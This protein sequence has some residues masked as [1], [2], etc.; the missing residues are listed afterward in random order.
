MAKKTLS[1]QQNQMMTDEISTSGPLNGQF[2][3]TDEALT[4]YEP[5]ASRGFNQL[6][7]VQRQGRWFLLK[8]LKPEFQQQPVYLELL[9]KEYALMVQL[10]HPNIVKAYAK[11]VNDKLGPCI[12]MEYID[13]VKLDEF[14]AGKPPRQARRKVVDQLVDA[15][16]YLHSK[17]I[18]H[19]DL[20]PSNILV[21]RNGNNV[22]IIDFGLSD[23]DDYAVLKQSAGTLSYMAPEQMEQSQK[24]DCRAD[25]YSLGLLLRLIFPHRYRFIEAKCMRKNPERRYADM[26][27][28]R[29]ALERHDR[30]ARTLP[31]LV[32]L[33]L[34]LLYGFLLSNRIAQQQ[35]TSDNLTIESSSPFLNNQYFK[36]YVDNVVI[37]Q[38]NTMIHPILIEAE[39]GNE[40]KEVLV[41]RLSH[42]S[43]DIKAL[44]HEKG[45]LYPEN[46]Q[47]SL[48][49]ITQTRKRQKEF[50]RIVLD[51]IN[52]HC[53]SYKED[54]QK[55]QISQTEY[56]SLEWLIS[57]RII[58]MPIDDITPTE[59]TG[60]I[61]VLEKGYYGGMELGLCWD[62][63]HNPTIKGRHSSCDPVSGRVV[64][65][66]LIPNTT[67]F[68]RA[69]VTNTAGT[70]Y[71]NEMTFT[72]LPSDSIIPLP[73]GA[74]PGLFSVS[75]GRQVH[76]SKG[77]LQ[78]QASTGTWRFAE[79]QYDFVGKDNEKISESF[80]GW[81]DLFGWATSGYDHG[82]VNWQP[83]SSNLVAKSDPLHYAYGDVSYNLDDLTGQA[84]WG[85]N[86]IS[87]G[88]NKENIG[89]HTPSRDDWM[90]LLFVR[91]TASGARFAKAVVG[92][93][94]GL[95]L[96]P[97]NW[98]VATY[99]LN[100]VNNAEL[101]YNTNI[102]SLSDWQQ[103][104]EPLGAVFLPEAGVRT[105]DGVFS[106][107]GY[108][109]TSNH[110][111]EKVYQMSFGYG[112]TGIYL[113]GH[114]GDG[115]SVR[116]VRE[117]E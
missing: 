66:R 105:I 68:A 45:C 84:D 35:I 24:L 107:A 7:K 32:V 83:W 77:N 88:G 76:F 23:A 94:N 113:A 27:A 56:D 81:I 47:E 63:L 36:D 5:L 8:G 102:I 50:E 2:L 51:Q 52:A 41:E 4:S 21:T 92:G 10:D 96:L 104:L 12:V 25:I 38:V 31:L 40:Y 9:K 46:S 108:Y 18:Q 72:T 115:Q 53:R 29:K 57:P 79:H 78:Y 11:E 110:T 30:R 39:Q 58:T 43:A 114:R 61:D 103:V 95:V 16:S 37:W 86:A 75:E 13:G 42:I 49:L 28:V 109:Q 19:R 48:E 112:C 111:I 54:F 17:Q 1:S 14:L 55:H 100:S 65:S 59:A 62:M 34:A 44:L 26:E 85:Y 116:L 87:N 6:V 99:Q 15:L 89:W 82:A 3:S 91:N 101:G 71:G 97:D 106:D 93:T 70:F 80:A 117:V 22:K 69:F 98:R 74:L 20:K 60:G 90:Y 73:E 67:Y 64:M 33:L